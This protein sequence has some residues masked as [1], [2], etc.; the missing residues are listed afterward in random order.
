MGIVPIKK[1]A[2]KQSEGWV[3]VVQ[4][5]NDPYAVKIGFTTDLKAR[6]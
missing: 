6:F 5:E 2:K 3:Y 4:W 1:V